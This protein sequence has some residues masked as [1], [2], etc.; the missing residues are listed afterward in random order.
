MKISIITAVYN[1]ADSIAEAVRSVQSQTWPQV[2]HV[3]I[4][5]ASTDGTV[6]V[7]QSCLNAQ[8]VWL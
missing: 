6:A 8:A 1:R 2:E 7:L 5:G 4:D 3:V